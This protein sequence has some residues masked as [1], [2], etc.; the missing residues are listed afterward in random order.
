YSSPMKASA[1]GVSTTVQEFADDLPVFELNQ[2]YNTTG[3][4]V[5][6]FPTLF[7]YEEGRLSSTLN[8][9]DRGWLVPGLSEDLQP[10]R[11][12]SAQTNAN[13]V[14]DI[15]GVLQNGPV[16]YAVTRGSMSNSGWQLIGNPYP[17]PIDWD[18]VRSTG[19]L[20][21]I[22]DAIYVHKPTGRY[23]GSYAAY[24]N[25]IGSNGGVKDLA[26]MQGFFVRA[27]QPTGAV[28]FTNA[29]RH[30]SYT[31]P[32]VFRPGTPNPAAGQKP[33]IRLE[34]RNAAGLADEAVVYFEAG[35]GLG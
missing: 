34:A 11:G 27:T 30:T 12:Y 24:V 3:N 17:A 5:T 32:T 22:E 28:S 6:P 20:T 35:A 14:V 2:A 29:A 19:M 21:G 15:A 23:T 4:T 1:N 31:A 10:L 9:F 26:S 18:V 33:V 25:G 16:S 7:T 13:T 8:T